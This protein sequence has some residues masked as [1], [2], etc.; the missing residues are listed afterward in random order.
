M[1]GAEKKGGEEEV[2]GGRVAGELSWENGVGA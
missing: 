1:V 2:G